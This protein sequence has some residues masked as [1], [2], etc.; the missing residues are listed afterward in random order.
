MGKGSGKSWA[1]LS[2]EDSS[3]VFAR[4]E[5]RTG[6]KAEQGTPVQVRV[7][8]IKKTVNGKESWH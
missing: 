6:D 2:P 7:Y 5:R 8:I 3:R 4:I 1:R